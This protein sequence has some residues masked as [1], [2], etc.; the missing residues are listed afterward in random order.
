MRGEKEGGEKERGGLT[1]GDPHVHSS[2]PEHSITA[3]GASESSVTTT[4]P[5]PPGPGPGRGGTQSCA[6]RLRQDSEGRDQLGTW[7]IVGDEG[8]D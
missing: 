5:R 4:R 8:R 2:R 6:A 3:T 7:S 1:C